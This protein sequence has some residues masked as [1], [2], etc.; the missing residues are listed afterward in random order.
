MNTLIETMGSPI[1]LLIG[2]GLLIG[3][4]YINSYLDKDKR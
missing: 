1:T 2:M 4:F 3:M